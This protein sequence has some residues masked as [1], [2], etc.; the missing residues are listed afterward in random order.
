VTV[1][2]ADEPSS[3]EPPAP[4]TSPGKRFLEDRRR[5]YAQSD[6]RR[7][8]AERLARLIAAD[9]RVLEARHSPTN[10]GLSSAL[11]VHAEDAVGV[12]KR[13]RSLQEGVRILVNGPWPPYSFVSL[14]G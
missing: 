8:E 14:E 5:H 3:P 2:W 10:V 6:Q 1:T 12:A 11:L 7:A 13:L 4:A 9:E